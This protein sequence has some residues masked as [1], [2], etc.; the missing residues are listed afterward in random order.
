[1]I[2]LLSVSFSH[3]FG[4]RYRKCPIHPNTNNNYANDSGYFF[5]FSYLPIEQIA[6][7]RH[8]ILKKSRPM[9]IKFGG[10]IAWYVRNGSCFFAVVFCSNFYGSPYLQHLELYHPHSLDRDS[11]YLALSGPSQHD[12]WH[13]LLDTE[14]H[15]HK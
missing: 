14:T 8:E 4:L 15:L 10:K 12:L 11:H 6:L 7:C 1:M 5:F 9:S 3:M 13:H 2:I